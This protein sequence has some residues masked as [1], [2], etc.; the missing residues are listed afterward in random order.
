MAK[1]G[2]E[3]Q[4]SQETTD[5]NTS[6]NATELLNLQRLNIGGNNISIIFNSF[7]IFTM[8]KLFHLLVISRYAVQVLRTE[9]I[10]PQR[11]FKNTLN[12]NIKIEKGKVIAQRQ[13]KQKLQ[14][15][16]DKSQ[17]HISGLLISFYQAVYEICLFS[18]FGF[19]ISLKN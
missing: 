19:Y 16:C 8:F 4:V 10:S 7:I 6:Q 3:G 11:D 14:Q 2:I 15:Q 12:G 13:N 9:R 5:I 18:P 17:R 1:Y